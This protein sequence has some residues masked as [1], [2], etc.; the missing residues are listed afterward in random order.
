[1][2]P[3]TTAAA[4]TGILHLD[5]RTQDNGGAAL[6]PDIRRF[7]QAVGAEFARHP[8]F[9]A[10]PTARRRQIAE[11]VRAPWAAGGPTMA[12]RVDLTIPTAIGPM[13]A[14]V[15]NP[16]PAA[17]KPGL[18]YVHGG[19][20]TLFSIDTHDRVMREYA[21]R[22]GLVVIG[23]DYALSPETRYPGAL[24]QVVDAVRWVR[25]RAGELDI[26]ATRLALG[27]D[28]AGGN[29]TLAACVKLR[30]AGE[31]DAV[32]A[33]LL[34]YAALDM[35][36]SEASLQRYGGPGYML[37]ADE[38]RAF[39]RGYVDG[40]GDPRDPLL[41]PIHA[42]LEGLP[43]AL[44]AIAECDI[45]AEQNLEAAARLR[46]AGVNAEAIVYAGASHS[47]LEAVSIARVSER[48]FDDAARW[49]RRTLG[50]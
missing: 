33:M 7:V 37:G 23:L 3:Q 43:P 25:E 17:R 36:C 49:L 12:A 13:R 48:A 28:S 16:T 15:H 6:D 24:L 47:F 14:R 50:A 32:R 11:E 46:A 40:Q 31:R 8:D 27:G 35:H 19:G 30:D 29:L 20:W 9:D 4:T 45:L 1:L 18:I 38:M 44:F 5:G 41:C 22:A 26:D 42:R 10:L 21:A 2:I 39:W 34:N